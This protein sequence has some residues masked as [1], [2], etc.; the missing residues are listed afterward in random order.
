[1][2][3]TVI[4]F[5]FIYL[6][7]FKTSKIILRGTRVESV[8]IIKNVYFVP[9]VTLQ[10]LH[11]LVFTTFWILILYLKIYHPA[12]TSVL[13]KTILVTAFDSH[14]LLQI[15]LKSIHFISHVLIVVTH[16]VS[17]VPYFIVQITCRVQLFM[18]FMQFIL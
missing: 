16:L 1:M 2:N 18:Q 12:R 5:V 3:V 17:G 11:V 9:E 13:L 14:V 8:F 15:T 6:R 7:Y 10:E 4:N